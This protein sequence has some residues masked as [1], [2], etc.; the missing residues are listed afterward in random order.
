MFDGGDGALLSTVGDDAPVAGAPFPVL[1]LRDE[2]VL[3]WITRSRTTERSQ[4]R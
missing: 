1:P 3:V 2:H 4:L